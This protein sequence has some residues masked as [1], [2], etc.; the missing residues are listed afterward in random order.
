[1]E[2]KMNGVPS[3]SFDLV[4]GGPQGS[5]TGQLLYII[6]SDDAAE[7]V[8]DDD[9]F[10]Y[11]DDLSVLEAFI[12][13]GKLIQYDVQQHVPS[14][15]AT[16]QLFLPPSTLETQNYNDNIVQWTSDNKIVLNKAKSNYIVFSRS[17]EQFATRLTLDNTKLNREAAIVHLGIWITGELTW[18]KNIAEICK[19]AYPRVNMLVKLKYV[20]VRTEDMIELYCL[21]IRSITEY[22]STAFHSS[23]S[24]KISNKIES[25]QKRCLRVILGVMFVD[26][27]SALE[28]CGLKSLHMRREHRSL[29]FA[30]KCTKHPTNSK[31]F[32]LNPST[33]THLVKH[34][35]K[36]KVNTCH[37]EYY[38][39]SQSHTYRE[40][41]IHTVRS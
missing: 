12:L 32:P 33:D 28:M 31:P 7:D 16:D 14:D 37:S 27:T 8:P 3:E 22:C 21:H 13:E 29:L 38:K 40:D 6:A 18:E 26:Y 34:R 17:R 36:Y 2:L 25:I 39:K 30:L 10:K 11:I 9:K 15:I 24:V 5:L 23:L 1:M 41:S 20:G 35:E 4:G 19:K